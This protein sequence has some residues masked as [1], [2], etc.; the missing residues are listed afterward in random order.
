MRRVMGVK[1]DRLDLDDCEFTVEY[2]AYEDCSGPGPDEDHVEVL[3]VFLE[4]GTKVIE[5][6]DVLLHSNDFCEYV[7]TT[8]IDSR[9]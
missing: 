6:T 3:R 1:F 5:V 9:Y 4:C 7:R 8:V 2:E